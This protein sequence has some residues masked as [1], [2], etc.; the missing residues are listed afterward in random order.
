MVANQIIINAGLYDGIK[1]NLKIVEETL[2]DKS[3]V[4][5]VIIGTY[6][7]AAENLRQAEQ[8]YETILKSLPRF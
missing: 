4:Y 8:I 1:P 7:Y 3:R 6:E 2:S 5:N